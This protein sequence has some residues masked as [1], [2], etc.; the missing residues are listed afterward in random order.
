VAR[1][2][3]SSLAF[4]ALL[5]GVFYACSDTA[6]VAGRPD[7]IGTGGSTAGQNVGG[8]SVSGSSTGG[9]G[10]GINVGRGGKGGSSQSSG[11]SSAKG[12]SSQA[13]DEQ[14]GY[15]DTPSFGGFPDVT[16]EYDPPMGGEGGA[17][18]S[19]TGQA[20]LV[21]RPMDIIIAVD[22]SLSMQGEIQAVQARI[23]VDFAAIIAASG[24]DYRVIIVSR[25][26]D[27]YVTNYDKGEASDSAYSICI[28][29]PLSALT[30]PASSD[31]TGTTT[32]PV[33]NNPPR[34]FHHST[35]IG[36]N[37][38]WCQLIKAYGT[39]DPISNNGRAGW[40]PVAPNG[41]QDF[42][43]ED[44]FK[45]F[46]AITDDSPTT[47]ATL[48]CPGLTND[49]AGAT[50]F[51]SE[52]RAL[53]PKQFET[54]SGDR[55]YRWYSI[56]GMYADKANAV[57]TPDDPVE[58]RCCTAAGTPQTTCQGTTGMQLLNSSNP[59]Q[60]YQ[61]LAIMTGGLRYPSCYNDNF[62]DVF[63]AI[64]QGVIES[65]NASC[66]YDVPTP[67]HG[68]VD[69][70]QTKVAYKPGGTGASVPLERYGSESACGSHDGFYYSADHEQLHL[71][72]TTCSTVQA[73]ANAKVA[74]DFGCLGS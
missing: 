12:G 36:S 42:V 33:A 16:F 45:V 63:Q 4:F 3:S 11:G 74:I 26:G 29:A 9:S 58:T 56:V 7:G 34:F 17:C 52:L 22:N 39:S 54:A 72:P 31:T 13:G 61:E 35:D 71:C 49:L 24:I 60:G 28:G 51:D 21:K 59:G 41:W 18:A 69:F 23:N 20:T 1:R 47:S 40:A 48:G 66:V 64:A 62:N 8:S 30:C 70:E 27:V 67:S 73:D 32:P 55:N 38:L 14:G 46:V 25:Y 68:I 44:A 6:S 43:R 5:S 53:A 65:A 50:A 10:N 19:E 37:N 2:I 57:L 15:G